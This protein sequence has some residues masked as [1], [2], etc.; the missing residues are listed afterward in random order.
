MHTRADA[1]RP[2]PDGRARARLR[3]VS[4][5]DASTKAVT[6]PVFSGEM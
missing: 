3:C 1:S 5:R 4:P 2:A 6:R